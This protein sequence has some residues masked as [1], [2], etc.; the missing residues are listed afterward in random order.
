MK[1]MQP[2]Q[3][4]LDHID[5]TGNWI[6]V[7]TPANS[8]CSEELRTTAFAF[9]PPG[10]VHVGRTSILPNGGRLTVADLTHLLDVSSATHEVLG[11]G[12]DLVFM[13]WESV[14]LNSKEEVLRHQWKAKAGRVLSVGERDGE[15][16]EHP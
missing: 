12:F 7:V 5:R 15:M 4:V 8:E 3:R 1:Y 11:S 13:G 16:T 14:R 10:S 2:L 6:V 9:F